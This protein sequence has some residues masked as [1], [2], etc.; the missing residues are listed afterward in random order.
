MFSVVAVWDL[1]PHICFHLQSEVAVQ[2]LDQSLH[3]LKG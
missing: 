1:F 3:H 2:C